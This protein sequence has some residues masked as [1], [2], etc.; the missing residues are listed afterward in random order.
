MENIIIETINH[1]GYLGIVLLIAIENLFP[2]IPSEVML[3]FGGFA[4]TITNITLIGAIIAS[5]I[6]SVIG[7]IIL[8]WIGYI[9]NEE[10]LY[11]FTKSK[12]GK[13]LGI[14]KE[15]IN[16][17]FSW[18]NSKGNYAV[19]F[20]R[21]IPIVRSLVS[22]PAGM[23]KMPQIPFI[24]LTTIGSLIW[25]T[26]LITLGKIAGESWSK[27]AGYVGGYSDIIWIVFGIIFI[28][29]TVSYYKKKRQRIQVIIFKKKH[30]K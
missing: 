3:T 14:K 23:S 22:I 17:A 26:L 25:N 9:L 13:I 12:F 18:F 30:A 15:N 8:Y 10:K 16:K 7:A 27:I 6:G 5:T 28:L 1:F 24:I 29:G 21:F 2:P 20:G 4:T 11:S 19:F